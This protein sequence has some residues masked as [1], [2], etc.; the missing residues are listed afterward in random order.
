MNEKQ[1]KEVL[2]RHRYTGRNGV[3]LL[4]EQYRRKSNTRGSLS[5]HTGVHRRRSEWGQERE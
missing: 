1:L 3:A 4:P 2:H 5:D